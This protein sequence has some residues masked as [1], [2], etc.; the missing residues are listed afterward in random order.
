M[1]DTILV[2]VILVALAVIVA[3]VL[4]F[5]KP[6]T[7]KKE[8]RDGG[9]VFVFEAKKDIKSVELR[10]KQKKGEVVFG[11][12]NIRKGERIEFSYEPTEEKAVLTVENGGK[13]TYEI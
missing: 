4:F 10:V 12:Q 11:R 2:A 1:I 13:K 8:L 9:I 7:W 6:Y 5:K 3:L